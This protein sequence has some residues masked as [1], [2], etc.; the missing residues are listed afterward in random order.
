MPASRGDEALA[1]LENVY[2]CL[3]P[4]V[5]Y[6]YP[7]KKLI[8]KESLDIVYLQENLEKACDELERIVNK[9]LR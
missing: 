2:S 9:I 6:F 7:V 3:N 8:A 1:A 5:N 4:L